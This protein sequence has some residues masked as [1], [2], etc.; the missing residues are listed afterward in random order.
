[1]KEF[2]VNI[3]IQRVWKDYQGVIHKTYHGGNIEIDHHV[4]CSMSEDVVKHFALPNFTTL[5][6]GTIREVLDNGIVPRDKISLN[7]LGI[8]KGKAGCL[9]MMLKT[10]LEVAQDYTVFSYGPQ[11]PQKYL[12]PQ[13]KK[14][15]A[16]PGMKPAPKFVL[17]EHIKEKTEKDPPQI[18]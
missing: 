3:N 5:I 8:I 16:G 12:K 10:G 6:P 15:L 1:M 11:R 2:Y 14:I 7:G 9:S 17:P 13:N 4:I 18:S